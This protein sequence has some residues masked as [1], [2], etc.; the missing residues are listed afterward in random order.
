MACCGGVRG[1][2]AALWFVVT[3]LDLCDQFRRL[4]AEGCFVMPNPWDVGSAI[5]L[6]ALGF[7]AIGTS[8]AGLCYAMG[9]PDS[10]TALSV[11][12]A[13]GH[14]AAVVGA[15]ALPVSADFEAGYAVDRDVLA[16]NVTRCVQTGV[17]GLSIEDATGDAVQPLYPLAEAVARVQVA[18]AAIDQAGPG[19]VLTARAESYLCGHPDPLTDAITRLRA[20]ADAGADVLFAPGIKSPE[21]IATL[22]AA[23][24]PYPV[25]VVMSSDTGMTVADLARLGV[26]RISVGSA[27]SRV[28]WGAFLRAARA[29]L[30]EGSFTGLTGAAS[31]D[32]LDA[33]FGG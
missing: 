10:L 32:E 12:D 21:D 24:D 14:I 18:R 13:I 17:A 7:P 11:E 26:R 4:H 20:Y 19:V 15:V 33:L 31:F 25:N 6:S 9:R 30:G 3:Q 29:L 5:T 23:V 27:L 28:A 16:V 8:S 2:L 1:W 22:V